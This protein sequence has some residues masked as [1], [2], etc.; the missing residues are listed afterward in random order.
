[1]NARHHRL[2][3]ASLRFLCAA[4]LVSFCF[5]ASA[6]DRIATAR[7]EIEKKIAASGAEVSV[8]FRAL[9]GKE[10]LLIEPDRVYHAAS[11]MK[12]PVMIELFA[13]AR[14]GKLRL[15]DPLEVKNEFKS[16][17]DGSAYQLATGDDSDAE[18]YKLTGKTM[19][20][21]QLCEAMITVSSNL[22]TNLLIEKLGAPNIQRRTVALGADGMKVLRGVEDNKA[23]AAG[24]NNTTTAR[25]L[26]VLMERIAKGEAGDTASTEEMLA[27]LKR[28]K[29]VDGIPAGVPK[30]VAVA[31]KTGEITKIHH[32][33]AIIF[34]PRPFTLVILTRGLA[35]RKQ[36]AALMAEV[37]NL[38]YTDAEAPP[39][40]GSGA[41][42]SVHRPGR[43][44]ISA[45]AHQPKTHREPICPE[46]AKQK[47]VQGAVRLELLVDTSGRPAGIKMISGHPLL[48]QAAL[49]AVREWRYNPVLINGEPAEVVTTATVVFSF[50]KKK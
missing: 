8:A 17:V 21:R 40:S 25:A 30:G 46:L 11:T 12:V 7:A 31:N 50:R 32:D 47:G 16:L 24:M 13:Q 3:S 9:D 29:F 4:A 22:A 15:D 2:F 39:A 23:F 34:A 33:A 14:E 20:L 48:V 36:S 44:R 38:L 26:L 45:E 49:D 37:T 19:T 6:R 27:I 43:M 42:N 18:V 28:Q 10:E 5:L 1:V 41:A 35:D